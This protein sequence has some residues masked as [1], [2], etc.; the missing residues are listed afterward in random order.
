MVNAAPK[1]NAEVWSFKAKAKAIIIWP[2]GQGLAWLQGNTA[3]T[4][5]SLHQQTDSKLGGLANSL[6]VCAPS[7]MK[8][9]TTPASINKYQQDCC[10]EH[11]SDLCLSGIHDA[12]SR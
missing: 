5:T 6:G 9:R 10:T 1:A 3:L 2:Q 11:T 4:S 7:P 12:S 8:S